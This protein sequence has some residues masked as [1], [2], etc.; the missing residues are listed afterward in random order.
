MDGQDWGSFELAG[1][2]AGYDNY[3]SGDPVSLQGL[4]ADVGKLPHDVATGSS[5]LCVDTGDL[6]KYQGSTD[7]WY[8]M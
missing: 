7:T 4:A 8:K 6:Y 3:E 5:A 1:G 2:R